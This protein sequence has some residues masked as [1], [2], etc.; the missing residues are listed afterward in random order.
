MHTS[1]MPRRVEA[2]ARWL[3]PAY[4]VVLALIVFL[5]AREAGRLT[6]VIGW[7]AVQVGTLGIPVEPAYV[8]LEFTANVVLFLPFGAL[9]TIASPRLRPMAVIAIGFASS[10]V[11]ELVQL[12]IPSRYATVSDVIANTLGTAIGCLITVAVA[13]SMTPTAASTGPS[14]TPPA[15]A[16]AAP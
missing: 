10:V 16:S 2:A 5:P 15:E 7:L 1:R 12:A 11:I 6:G 14:A 8:V 3:F 4:L 13:R 9:A